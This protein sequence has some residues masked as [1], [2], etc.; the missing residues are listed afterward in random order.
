MRQRSVWLMGAAFSALV[1]VGVEEARAQAASELNEC[2]ALSDDAERLACYDAAS[3]LSRDEGVQPAT[4]EAE[5]AIPEEPTTLAD[6]R[7]E[8]LIRNFTVA[9]SALNFERA[10]DLLTSDDMLSVLSAT[11]KAQLEEALL[12]EVQPLPASDAQ[13]NLDG[14]KLLASLNPES[15]LYSDKVAQYENA[16]LAQRNEALR[17]LTQERDSFRSITFHHHRNEPRYIDTR[18]RIGLYIAEP[19]AGRPILRVKTVYTEDSWLFVSSAEVSIDGRVSNWTRGEFERDNDSDI[20]EWRDEVP[21][22]S[23]LTLLRDM[24]EASNVTIRFNGQQYYDDKTLNSDDRRMIRDVL[25]A[26]DAM[27]LEGN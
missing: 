2:H 10:N 3:G 23:Q 20:W 7:E 12:A 25:A 18:S 14:Y 27:I 19:D 8:A 15:Q 16:I 9:V 17:S 24:A 22:P 11:A 1:V 6:A 21:S 4:V 26:Y 13:L 5:P